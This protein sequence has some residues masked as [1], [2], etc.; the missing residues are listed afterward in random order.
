MKNI[1][2]PVPTLVDIKETWAKLTH[3]EPIPT[4]T[5]L[6]ASRFVITLGKAAATIDKSNRSITA[7]N[8]SAAWS[9]DVVLI[10][11]TAVAIL[12]EDGNLQ[13]I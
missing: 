10:E 2:I 5:K 12:F 3:R 7:H 11:D 8:C 6:S 4:L 1:T 13:L 9:G